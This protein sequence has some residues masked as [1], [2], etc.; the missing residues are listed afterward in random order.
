[1]SRLRSYAQLV[2]LP[3][4]PTALAD[5]CLGALTADALPTHLLPFLFLLLATACL[6]CG[7]MVWN[8][9]FDQDQDRRERPARPLP[10]GQVMPREAVRLGLG[11]LAAGVCFACLA[12]LSHPAGSDANSYLSPLLAVLLVAAI[13]LYD[14]W[15]KRTWLGPLGMGACRFLNVLL[16][17]SVVGGLLVPRGLHL[18]AIVGLYIVGV[19]WFARTEAR[20]SSPVAL[21]GAALVMLFSLCLAL[22]LPEYVERG[23]SSPLFP[24][25]L[26]ALA[27]IV[28][29]P[30]CQAI[31][32]PTPERV[33]AGVKRA[34][35]GLILLD[36][37][38]ASAFAGS[39]GLLIL[40]LLTPTL[41]L[42]RKRW[43]YAT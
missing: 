10:S 13:L 4:L 9:Y 41:Y 21:G 35:F 34:L 24:Y 28:G 38:L 43:L 11:L 29:I 18:A 22:P 12:G 36:A 8:D 32:K 40:L 19:T 2:R 30:V 17:V 23:K 7:G 15:L 20:R 37:I 42:N 1:M 5:I 25:L 3:A 16:G 27:F 31:V 6:Y 26:V 33:Q 14:R 39:M